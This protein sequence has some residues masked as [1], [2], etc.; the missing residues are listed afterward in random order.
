GD[1]RVSCSVVYRLEGLVGT[2]LPPRGLEEDRQ[3]EL[4]QQTALQEA[5]DAW[6]EVVNAG[7]HERGIEHET[8]RNSHS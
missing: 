6:D 8:E 5:D 4:A 3:F 1:I 7:R 2:L